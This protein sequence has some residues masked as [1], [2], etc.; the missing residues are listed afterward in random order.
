MTK[1]N[2]NL[3][4]LLEQL[5]FI[6]DDLVD[7]IPC[8][9]GR[10]IGRKAVL[11]VSEMISMIV[12][13]VLMGFKTV[14]QLYRFIRSY[15]QKEFPQMPKY[16]NFNNLFNQYS[17]KALQVLKIIM[18]FNLQHST[19]IKAVDATAIA[20]CKNKRIFH[21]KVCRDIAE[22]GKSSMGWFYGFK[23]HICVDL[24]GKL[25][26]CKI[27][28]GN[29]DDR[30]PVLDLLK[31]IK[32]IVLADAGYVSQELV[33]TLQKQGV[34]F[35]TAVKG[36]MKKLMTNY[37]HKTLKKRQIVETAF[38][39]Q[40]QGL[41]LVSSFARSVTGHFSRIIYCLLTYSLRFLLDYESLKLIS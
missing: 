1:T 24:K 4:E 22:R 35:I 38:G 30:K 40:K 13:G 31:K 21:H 5:F 19:E 8:G 34:Q 23:L 20:V 25:L 10:R 26:S 7:L 37:Q 27:T 29:T 33:K 32:G 15:H 39:V 3:K 14:K 2:I 11:C 41:N 6:I 12:F 36:N 18:A 9:I 28:P 17:C 16:Q